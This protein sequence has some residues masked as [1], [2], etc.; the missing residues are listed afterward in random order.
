MASKSVIKPAVSPSTL[1]LAPVSW[2]S[3][4]C[5]QYE[6]AYPALHGSYWHW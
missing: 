3:G 4:Q 6:A 2:L 1:C 5:R